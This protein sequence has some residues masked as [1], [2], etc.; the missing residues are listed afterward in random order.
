MGTTIGGIKRAM[1]S[2]NLRVNGLHKPMV[3]RRSL[4]THFLLEGLKFIIN[5]QFS[6]GISPQLNGLLFLVGSP[7]N[8]LSPQTSG[9]CRRQH[10]SSSNLTWIWNSDNISVPFRGRLSW[11]I[12]MH[13][14]GED[15]EDSESWCAQRRVHLLS[16]VAKTTLGFKYF[17]V[18]GGEFL[19]PSQGKH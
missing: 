17:W 6:G 10:M 15:V 2:I 5:A 4:S 13:I 18:L 1:H 3:S 12:S 11:S 19:A 16:V 8:H 14:H 9:E 7:K